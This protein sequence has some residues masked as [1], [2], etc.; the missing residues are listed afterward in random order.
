LACGLL[1]AFYKENFSKMGF[2]I[3]QKAV[4]ASSSQEKIRT[5]L[6]KR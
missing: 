2:K 5:E 6:F 3:F 1:D 4:N